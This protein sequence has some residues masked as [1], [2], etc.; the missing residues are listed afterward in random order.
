[1][2]CA[3]TWKAEGLGGGVGGG[4]VGWVDRVGVGLTLVLPLFLLHGRGIAEGVLI[5]VGGLFLVRSAVLGAWGWLRR[6][7]VRVA[8]AWWGWLV[9]C[10]AGQGGEALGQAVGVVRF[11]LL[12]AALEEWTLRGAGVRRWLARLLRWSAWYIAVQ[13]LVQFGTG[14]NLFGYPRGAD[15]ELTGPYENPRAGPPLSRLLFPAVLPGLWG[16]MR[17]GRGFGGVLVLLGGVGV[18]VLIGQRMPLL[19]VFLGLFVTALLMPGLRGVVLMALVGTGVVLGATRVAA[20]PTFQRL[21]VKFSSQMEH[22]PSSPYGQIAARAVAIG[23]AH[24]V[25]GMG[26]DGFRRE[27]GSAEYFRGWGGGNGGRAGICVQHPHNFYLQALVEGGVPGLVLFGGMCGAWLVRLGRGL[28][29]GARSGGSGGDWR[30]LRVGLFVAAVVHLWPVASTTAW[31]SMPLGGWFFVLL[32]LG[33]A[34][35]GAWEVRSG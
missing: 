17:G 34:E 10:S 26:F 15:G 8:L 29:G 31:T 28:W 3:A 32:G 14:R 19:L 4:L 6:G 27:C 35:V 12:V 22:F 25:M 16:G 30:A 33:L 18:M 7:W 23:Q 13:A 5:G 9:V 2:A 21:V 1:M 11:L 24:P 20:P